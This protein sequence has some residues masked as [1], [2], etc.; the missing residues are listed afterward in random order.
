[1][2][3]LAN[4]VSTRYLTTSRTIILEFLS[5]VKT[6]F[7]YSNEESEFFMQTTTLHLTISRTIILKFLDL[8]NRK[9][10]VLTG[11]ISNFR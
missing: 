1:M 3:T 9:T 8:S 10:I 6:Y 4:S 7:K 2:A 11:A 5:C